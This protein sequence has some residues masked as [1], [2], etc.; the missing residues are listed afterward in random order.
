MIDVTSKQIIEELR[1]PRFLPSPLPGLLKILNL[2]PIRG[3]VP[4]NPIVFVRT[5]SP[6]VTGNWQKVFPNIEPAS[7]EKEC[8]VTSRTE[9]QGG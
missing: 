6:Y 5:H 2:K 1:I 8:A 4:G 3:S 7:L 9:E